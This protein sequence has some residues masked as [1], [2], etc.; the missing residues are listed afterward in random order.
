[1]A[2][3]VFA[4]WR[5]NSRAA[6]VR[7]IAR[8]EGAVRARYL[9]EHFNQALVAANLLG[10]VA[11]QNGGPIPNFDLVASDI[12]KT[13]PG[14]DFVTSEPGGVVGEVSPRS[15]HERALGVNVL[16][17]PL[18]GAS[19]TAAVQKRA[20]IVIGPLAAFGRP[21]VFIVRV[22]VFRSGREYRD[23]FW[24]FVALG[25]TLSD[26]VE[27]AGLSD[28]PALGLD[29]V[30]Y[31]PAT[32]SEPAR[33]ITA[34]GKQSSVGALQFAVRVQG[35]ELRL[36]L[37]PVRGWF[38]R[39]RF[40]LE[41]A[42]AGVVSL[43]V[44]MLV[45]LF[46]NKRDLE[47]NLAE[48]EQRQ[49][50]EGAERERALEEVRQS[51]ERIVTLQKDLAHQEVT[52]KEARNALAQAEQGTTAKQRQ[53]EELRHEA[54]GKLKR[55]EAQA[56]ELQ[57]QVERN[58]QSAKEAEELHSKELKEAREA[59]TRANQVG[60]R[61]EEPIESTSRGR[62]GIARGRRKTECCRAGRGTASVGC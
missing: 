29:Y 37:K 18:Q 60:L 5:A 27:K 50:S 44:S 3:A 8:A 39:S 4:T 13:V 34:Q 32:G 48:V 25:M 10:T 33:V 45:F 31:T 56:K 47:L 12:L 61:D 15:G 22:P 42:G 14:S 40:Y 11:R 9:E 41:L 19:A 35:L 53:T 59:L 28:L 23:S 30:L 7:E 46:G 21:P 24:G 49:M 1:M 58:R 57:A 55:A 43:L 54:E 6:N 16:K 62:A 38:N 52:L 20:L 26:A 2:G 17:D 51:K 36:A